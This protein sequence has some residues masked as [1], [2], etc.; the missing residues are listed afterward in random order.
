MQKKAEEDKKKREAAQK[1]LKMVSRAAEREELQDASEADVPDH[2]SV[3]KKVPQHRAASNENLKDTYSVKSATPPPPRHVPPQ[4]N[5]TV[6]KKPSYQPEVN[7]DNESTAFYANMASTSEAQE[8]PAVDMV[9]CDLCGRRFAAD[10]LA[11]HT[12]ICEKVS[13]KKRKV[14]DPAKMRAKGTDNEPYQRVGPQSA[15]VN[16]GY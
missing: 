7:L 2:H 3:K 4:Q 13:Q 12:T 16:M 15:K 8:A 5:A 14:F 6:K 9:A 10:R 1:R 11:K